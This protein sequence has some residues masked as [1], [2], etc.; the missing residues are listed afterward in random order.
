MP[1]TSRDQI[2]RSSCA[3]QLLRVRAIV[4]NLRSTMILQMGRSY[5]V[6]VC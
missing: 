5:D 6:E 2:Q 3:A 4:P 1:P